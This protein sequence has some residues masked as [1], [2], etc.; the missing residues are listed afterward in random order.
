MDV[1][2]IQDAIK[3]FV[4]VNDFVRPT[5]VANVLYVGQVGDWRPLFPVM[6]GEE[7]R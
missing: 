6:N 1:Q 3:V 4:E 2:A 5:A 7:V